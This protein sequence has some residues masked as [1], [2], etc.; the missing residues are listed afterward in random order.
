MAEPDVVV[1]DHSP[2]ALLGSRACA[3]RRFLIGSG[4]CI[5]PSAPDDRRPDGAAGRLPWGLLWRHP[6]HADAQKLLDFEDD[7][8]RRSNRVLRQWKQAPMEWLGQLYGEADVTLLTTFPELEQYPR[9]STRAGA[10][11]GVRYWGPVE[12]RDGGAEA[13]WPQGQGPRVFAYLKEFGGLGN[14]LAALKARGCPTVVYFDGKA[15]ALSAAR[16]PDSPTLRFEPKRLDMRRVAAECDVAVLHAGQGATAALLRAGKPIL[17]IP[18]VL[19]QRLTALATE[20]LGAA[21]MGPPR[22]EDAAELGRKLDS[23]L[24]DAA[25]AEAARRFA[26]THGSFDPAVQ[27]ERMV[28][29][30]EELMQTEAGAV[31]PRASTGG[32]VFAG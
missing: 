26:R 2:T 1:F 11:G 27:L 22:A 6:V 28:G 16:G 5:P 18:L 7:I 14:L 29:R 19:E 32:K 15:G 13:Q 3:M 12:G 23:L 9:R 31:M 10:G 8:L 17:Q 4:F 21:V 25:L 30:V 24:D 20:R